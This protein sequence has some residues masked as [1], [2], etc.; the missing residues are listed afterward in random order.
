MIGLWLKK[1]F[2]GLF[3]KALSSYNIAAR[4]FAFGQC[5]VYIGSNNP[6]FHFLFLLIYILKIYMFVKK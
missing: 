5:I 1:L 4:Y 2:L 3:E 6:A